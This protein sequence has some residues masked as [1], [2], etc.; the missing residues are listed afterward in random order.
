MSKARLVITAVVVE[1]RSVSEVARTYG[2]SRSWVHE[3]VA[4]HRAEGDQA[5]EPRSRAPHP[6]TPA[7][8]YRARPKATPTGTHNPQWRIRHDRVHSGNV[9][10]RING[11]LHRIALGRTLDRTPITALIQMSPRPLKSWK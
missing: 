8:A 11:Q 5:F 6:T 3:L 1:G 9:T 7:T 4:R 2:L 10:L